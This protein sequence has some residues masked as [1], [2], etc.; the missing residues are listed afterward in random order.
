MIYSFLLGKYFRF[1][2]LHFILP[3]LGVIIP[4]H[5]Y[6]ENIE[7]PLS[8]PGNICDNMENGLYD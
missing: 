6:S 3:V 5:E 4:Y 1:I 2:Y 8:N 7:R